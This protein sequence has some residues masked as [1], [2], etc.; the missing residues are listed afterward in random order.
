MPS[1][2]EISLSAASEASRRTKRCSCSGDP[3]DSDRE[4]H[5]HTDEKQ[6]CDLLSRAPG[7]IL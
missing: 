5:Q 1:C 6:L 2:P 7:I 3:E 4:V